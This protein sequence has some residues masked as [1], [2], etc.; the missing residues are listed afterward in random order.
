MVVEDDGVRRAKVIRPPAL[1]DTLRADV[2]RNAVEH[3]W[4]DLH[5]VT[6]DNCTVERYAWHLGSA[7]VERDDEHGRATGYVVRGDLITWA[8][9]VAV[10]RAATAALDPAHVG[11]CITGCAACDLNRA[12][13]RLREAARTARRA[14]IDIETPA[15][16]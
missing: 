14:G 10:A 15:T 2:A 12:V 6:G 8:D 1:G 5:R 9:L 7:V 11:A 3:R 4:E 13:G 16:N